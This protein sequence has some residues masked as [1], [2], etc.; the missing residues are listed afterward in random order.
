MRNKI[1]TG[2]SLLL[3]ICSCKSKNPHINYYKL[4][5]DTVDVK[6]EKYDS[7]GNL[8]GVYYEKAGLPHGI[9]E[10]Y[11]LNGKKKMEGVWYKGKETGWFK[12]YFESGKL[13]ALRQY[14]TI[15]DPENWNNNDSYL[16][17]VIRFN[18]QGDTVKSG[19]FFMR[20]GTSGDTIQNGTPYGFRITLAAP[21]FK[22][23][24]VVL[25][26]F[27][28]KY[29]LLPNAVCDTFGVENYQRTFSPKEYHLG[30]NIIRGKIVNFEN[31]HDSS[32]TATIYF[33]D[34]FYVKP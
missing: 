29:T 11:F 30:E 18:Q 19:S 31:D 34:K 22:K 15:N 7:L 4:T 6:Y 25:G 27:D 9:E 12:Y 32:T 20:L 3:I 1:I 23:M 33:T 16:N 13:Q 5:G 28:D 14:I 17:Q 26:D 21:L 2:L 8:A 10:E 24:Y